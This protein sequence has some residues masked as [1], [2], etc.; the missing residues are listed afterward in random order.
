MTQQLQITGIFLLDCTA[1]DAR[2]HFQSFHF[3]F[4]SPETGE[5]RLILGHFF[6]VRLL[7][8]YLQT[9][10]LIYPSFFKDNSCVTT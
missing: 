2:E 5:Q 6:C 1:T 7:I 8:V 3:D 10:L 9:L 4:P